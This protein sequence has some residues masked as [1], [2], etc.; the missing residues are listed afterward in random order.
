MAPRLRSIVALAA[1][2]AI[3]AA[4][5]PASAAPP[6]PKDWVKRK[7]ASMTLEEKV[8]QMF[9]TYGYGET[10][11]D[12]DPAMVAANRRDHS[13][14]NIAQLIDLATTSAA[15]STSRGRTTSTTHS[16]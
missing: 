2:A 1:V 15:L 3:V 6:G 10:V 7:I 9:M 14:D 5:L 8:G 11:E 13:V 12:P 4:A 16:R